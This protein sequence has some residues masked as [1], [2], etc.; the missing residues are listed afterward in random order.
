MDIQTNSLGTL[1]EKLQLNS[2]I[3]SIKQRRREAINQRCQEVKEKM[4]L[5][6]D[7]TVAFIELDSADSFEKNNDPKKALRKRFALTRRWTQFIT[8]NTK[9][10]SHRAKI[11]FLDLLRQ[12]GIQA[13]PP[14]IEVTRIEDEQLENEELQPEKINYVGIEMIRQYSPTSS[15]GSKFEV[16]VMVYMRSD[17]TEIKATAPG[18]GGEWFLYREVLLKIAGEEIHGYENPQDAV[19]KFIKPKL[20]EVLSL[21]DTLLL[22]HAQNFRNTWK[23]LT[24]GNITQDKIKFGVEKP[25]PIEDFSSNLRMIRI[26]DSQSH[27]T[28][29]WYAQNQKDEIGFSKGVFRMGERVFASTYNTPKTFQLNRSLSKV[30]PYPSK[31]RKTKEE[32][33]NPPSP[34][35]YYWNPGLVELTAAC[36]QPNDNPLLWTIITHELRHLALHHDEPLKLPLPLHLASLIGEYVMWVDDVDSS[37][38][39]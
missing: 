30:S 13:K 21:G 18:L 34:D 36:I 25:V 17:S 29:E 35:V 8:T 12:L 19:T 2:N 23:W 6:S 5:A 27:E 3:R 16:P 39:D 33:I 22:S 11:G 9:N 31:N 32:K 38:N 28:P 10:L 26:R 20:E 1:G 14:K 4:Q 7:I 37:E 15:D 24:N